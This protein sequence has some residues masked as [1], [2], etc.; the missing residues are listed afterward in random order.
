MKITD[1]DPIDG[2]GDIQTLHIMLQYM[3]EILEG[4]QPDKFSIEVDI[5]G[6][7]DYASMTNQSILDFTQEEKKDFI[8]I[9]H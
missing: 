1:I 2:L 4:Y 9:E 8:K 3:S 5:E 7:L 6:A